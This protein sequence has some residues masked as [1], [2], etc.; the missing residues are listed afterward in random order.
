LLAG[1]EPLDFSN[2]NHLAMNWKNSEK[3]TPYVI[4]T[5]KPQLV[6]VILIFSLVEPSAGC[7]IQL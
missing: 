2:V 7:L 5:S 3:L 6:G 1:E 4:V